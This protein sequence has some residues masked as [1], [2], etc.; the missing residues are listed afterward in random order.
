MLGLVF[1]VSG[2]RLTSWLVEYRNQM[3]NVTLEV[4]YG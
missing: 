4:S 3:S 1:A 2:T